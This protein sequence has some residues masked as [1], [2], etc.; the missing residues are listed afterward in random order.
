M[1]YFIK[2]AILQRRGRFIILTIAVM[3]TVSVLSSLLTITFG[4][5]SKIGKELRQYGAN[6]IVTPVSGKSIP[7]NIKDEIR[8]LSRDIRA[9][10]GHLYGSIFIDGVP[11]EVTGVEIDKSPGMRVTG[12][13]PKD[14]EVLVGTGLKDSLGL[15]IGAVIRTDSGFSLRVSGFFEKGT[16]EDY[17]IIMPIETARR[18]LKKDG[19]SALLLNVDTRRIDTLK[20]TIESKFPELKAKTV[21]QIAVAEERLLKKIQLLMF[22]VTAVVLFSSVIALGS[23][24][25]ANIIERT[26][27]IGLMKALGATKGDIRNFFLYEAIVAG[28]LGGVL[29]FFLGVLVAEAVSRTAF[30]SFVPVIFAAFP[31][32]LLTGVVLSIF[33]TYLPVRDAMRA[34]AAT[35]LRGE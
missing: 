16:D 2:K 6:M 32:L 15:D 26:E 23:T 29:G 11:Y 34:S 35:I 4:A 30:G 25:G 27:E 10:T 19:Y 1:F 24:M 5:R 21:R 7:E 20:N 8:G 31:P 17:T 18:V 22:I 12:R 13:L 33:A 3:L 28:L 14:A 9:V